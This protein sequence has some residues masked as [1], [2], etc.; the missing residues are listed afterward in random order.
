VP[1]VK[2]MAHY[3][4]RARGGEGALREV[5][6]ILFDARGLWPEILAHYE[7]DLPSGGPAL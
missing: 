1:E 2:A 7:V 5:A 4:T 3:V 6:E